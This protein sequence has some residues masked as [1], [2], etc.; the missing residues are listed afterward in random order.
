MTKSRSIFSFVDRIQI[1]HILVYVGSVLIYGLHVTYTGS[2]LHI[3]A[4]SYIYG[5]CVNIG[6]LCYIYGLY[7]TYTGSMLIRAPCYIYG[8]YVTYTGSM[9]IYGLHVTYTGSMLIYSVY[10]T[11]TG[12]M[13][14]IRALC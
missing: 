4:L 10:V 13:L 8:L 3:L 5:L 12:S 1:S 2:M 11:Y 14:H 6:A 9:L 7:V